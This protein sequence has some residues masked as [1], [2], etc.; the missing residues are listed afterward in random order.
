MG[1]LPRPKTSRPVACGAA[2][3]ALCLL[4][5]I[6][7]AEDAPHLPYDLS[8]TGD[9]RLVA[10]DGEE[11][12]LDGGFGKLR[13]GAGNGT[14]VKIRPRAVEGT[15]AWQPHLTWSLGATIVAI[16]QRGQ[17]NPID[18]SEAYLTFKPMPVGKVKF[19]ARAGLF[20]PPIS[21]EHTGA[22]WAVR[23]TITPSAINSWIGEE[24]KTTGIEVTAATEISGNRLS[25]TAGL[26][27]MNDTAGTL[28]AFRGWA[29]HDE[30]VT[31]F[32]RQPLPP[33]DGFIGMVQAPSTR[34]VIN[35]DNRPGFYV[36]LIWAPP[37]PFELQAL[38]YDNRA[39]PEAVNSE[40]QWG[41]RTRFDHLGAILDIDDRTRLTGQA[42]T[43]R[44]RMGFKQDG[45]TWIDTRFRS[46]YLL[47]T[48]QVGSGS[49]AA[50]IEAFGTRSHGSII[51][52]E[53]GENG[54]AITAAARRPIA[55][56][57]TML[58]EILHVE[59]RREQRE[60]VDLS[61][62]QDQNLAQLALRLRM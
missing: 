4:P 5:G 8:V 41:W 58:I 61:P 21:L 6:A 22:E 17:E 1:W 11:S 12:W 25:V 34:P 30:K 37:G 2:I 9:V 16:A 52:P 43:G 48:R 27:G 47:V 40:L 55:P 10:V 15:I 35:L 29:L 44:T 20:W 45:S 31:A 28:L 62:K 39:D 60:D 42:I 26:F 51:G 38:H 18:L 49:V 50:R 32:S 53:Y 36:K 14:D 23:D 19:S 57:A 3:A 56:F 54:W 59:S 33:L 7:R 46:A 24:V 13:F